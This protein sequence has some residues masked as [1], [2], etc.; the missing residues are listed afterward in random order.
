MASIRGRNRA[1][2]DPSI[3]NM[4]SE[5]MEVVKDFVWLGGWVAAARRVR[6]HPA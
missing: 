4:V 5:L 3:T 1:P 2:R 6:G